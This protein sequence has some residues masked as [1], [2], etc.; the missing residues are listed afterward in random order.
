MVK[1]PICFFKQ[2]KVCLLSV[3]Y[4]Q[5]YWLVW[6]VLTFLCFFYSSM[7]FLYSFLICIL[8]YFIISLLTF[9][10]SALKQ[11]S[12]S[13]TP[14]GFW[15]VGERRDNDRHGGTVGKKNWMLRIFLY[16]GCWSLSVLSFLGFYCKMISI[17]K[18]D[19]L[20]NIFFHCKK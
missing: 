16:W 10:F 6:T 4:R 1:I 14:S 3:F 7:S 15:L 11:W 19:C 9:T 12:I 13:P 2:Y 8:I 18:W 17:L 20:Y 5:V